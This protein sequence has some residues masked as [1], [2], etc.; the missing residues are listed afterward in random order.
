MYKGV[1]LRHYLMSLHDKIEYFVHRGPISPSKEMLSHDSRSAE[2][3]NGPARSGLT[4]EVLA[5]NGLT[6]VEPDLAGPL[7]SS[8][9]ESPRYV[10][11]FAR[12]GTTFA[13][14]NL[15][16]SGKIYSR[17]QLPG[18]LTSKAD[19]R[20]RKRAAVY[21]SFIVQS[22][23]I[24]K[25]VRAILI[26]SSN[27]DEFLS[28]C[29]PTNGAGS[30]AKITDEQLQ[31]ISYHVKKARLER[32]QIV[33]F[34]HNPIYELPPKQ[35]EALL[36]YHPI[37]YVSGHTHWESSVVR[38]KIGTGNLL[39]LNVASTTDWPMEAMLLSIAPQRI[40]WRVYGAR[41]L[42]E[43]KKNTNRTVCAYQKFES[44]PNDKICLEFHRDK[45]DYLGYLKGNKIALTHGLCKM[46]TELRSI[47]EKWLIPVDGFTQ[48]ALHANIEKTGTWQWSA[49]LLSELVDDWR[50]RAREPGQLRNLA[51]CQAKEASS[52]AWH[53]DR[54][55][56]DTTPERS[57]YTM[58]AAT[59]STAVIK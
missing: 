42:E 50:I 8:A 5:A 2:E 53:E 46:Q 47:T 44:I 3:L 21:G 16:I 56:F 7:S 18:E 33:F 20:P 55:C 30:R 25:D 14:R 59:F 48:S 41:S 10:L 22:L 24:S 38:H 39:E 52:V 29:R 54:G 51:L 45:S 31:E 4:E 11:G 19:R 57:E 17:A 32:Q 34:A 35:R 28:P 9:N 37:A 58:P 23:D 49:E 1:W 6:R 26:D 36:Q 27:I 43:V 40:N 15:F 12:K 13:K